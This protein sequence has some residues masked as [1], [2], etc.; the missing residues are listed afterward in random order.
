MIP[1]G[2]SYYHRKVNTWL[3]PMPKAPDYASPH[4][5]SG[6]CGY[7]TAR[8]NRAKRAATDTLQAA[9][10]PGMFWDTKVGGHQEQ[11]GPSASDRWLQ[12]GV[13]S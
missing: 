6:N 9:T 4:C 2:K 3:D 11:L 8:R 7:C 1:R 13:K 5:Q 10:A 12:T